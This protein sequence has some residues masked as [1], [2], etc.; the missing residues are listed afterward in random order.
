MEKAKSDKHLA[1]AD[2][3]V[4]KVDFVDASS[5]PSANTKR[6]AKKGAQ[7]GDPSIKDAAHR[8]NKL[9]ERAGARYGIKVGFAK[10]VAPEAGAT[11]SNGRILPA[12][13]NRTKPNFSAGMT[14]HN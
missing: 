3:K 6:V 11:Q 14:D 9:V 4:S 2:A 12:A 10:Q 5:A 1:P 13:T 8:S 7:A